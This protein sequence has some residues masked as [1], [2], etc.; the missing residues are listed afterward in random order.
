[1]TDGPNSPRRVRRGLILAAAAVVVATLLPAASPAAAQSTDQEPAAAAEPASAPSPETTAAPDAAAA[2]TGEAAKAAGEHADDAEVLVD[3]QGRA[4]VLKP[5]DKIPGTYV[6][7]PDDKIQVRYGLIYD[8]A[9]END[10]RF[11]VKVYQTPPDTPAPRETKTPEPVPAPVATES[12][13]LSFA[14]FAG[15]LPVRG[16]WRNGFEVAD[17]NGDGHLDI[18]HGPTRKGSAVPRVF[19]GDG[20]GNWRLW[21]ETRFPSTPRLDYGDVAVADFDGD[22]KL[23]LAVASHLR[24]VTVFVQRAGGSFESWSEGLE[25][26]S[27]GA[28][29]GPADF[30]S[31][32]IVAVDWDRNGRPDLLSLGEG[33]R[34]VRD[35]RDTDPDFARG[36]SGPVVFFNQGDGSWKRYDQG[37]GRGQPAGDALAVG[38]LDGDGR[39]DF[40]TASTTFDARQIVFLG[41][42]SGGWNPVEVS[43]LPDRA[44]FRAV[45]LADFDGDGKLDLAVGYLRRDVEQNWRTGID[46]LFNRGERGWENRTVYTEEGR[47]T[48]W[49]LATGDLDAD[50]HSDLVAA[51]GDGQIWV[52]LGDG[53]G[54]FSRDEATGLEPPGFHC[55]GYAIGLADLDAKP[56]DELIAGFA[57]ETGSEVMIPELERR[58]PS[59]GGLVA[60]RRR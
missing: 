10:E 17:M 57:G 42:P 37:T 48:V 47:R 15:G 9:E 1:M 13:E 27:L 18:V 32:A 53:A 14:P 56:G 8:V 51:T 2:Q 44:T 4:Y 58:C 45:D 31:R 12:S 41:S 35:R 20:A 25:F 54:G 49:S 30:S 38:D 6:L 55:T 43:A 40:V 7:L 59:G 22:G 21:D 60:W 23:D 36:S 29:D 34:M 24:G 50:G 26:S 16:Q 33:P 39:P 5:Y 52:F 3:D 28:G 19:L 46:V 11:L